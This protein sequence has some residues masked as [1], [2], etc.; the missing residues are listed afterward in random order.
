LYFAFSPNTRLASQAFF[1]KISKI[2][3][4]LLSCYAI[5][6]LSFRM[7]VMNKINN[8]TLLALIFLIFTA[9]CIEIDVY[10]P[11]DMKNFSFATSIKEVLIIK[12]IGICCGSLLFGPLSD[13]WGCSIG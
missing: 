7:D 8:I 1:N 9:I 4:K 6:N 10:V 5:T 12:F 11:S 2:Q 13:S 3:G